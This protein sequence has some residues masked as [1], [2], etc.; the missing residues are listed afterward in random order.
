[1]VAV[2]Q[3]LL[4]QMEATHCRAKWEHSLGTSCPILNP[5]KTQPSTYN[6]KDESR[7]LIPKQ[8]QWMP[9]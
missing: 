2:T 3:K 5:Q 6:L 8:Q 1:M 7:F 9:V 4:Y